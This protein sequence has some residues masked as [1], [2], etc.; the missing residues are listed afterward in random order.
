MCYLEGL[1]VTSGSKISPV[2]THKHDGCTLGLPLPFEL[3]CHCASLVL[4]ENQV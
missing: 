1:M 2:K 4:T 3:R